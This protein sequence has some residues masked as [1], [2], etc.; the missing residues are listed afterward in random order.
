MQSRDSAYVARSTHL[1][2]GA[3]LPVDPGAS[4]EVHLSSFVRRAPA[5][6]AL[7]STLKNHELSARAREEFV[8]S[9][10][11]QLRA[12]WLVARVLHSARDIFKSHARPFCLAGRGAARR[13]R[14]RLCGFL[15]LPKV[16][17]V[18]RPIVYSERAEL[19]S[20]R[21]LVQPYAQTIPLSP[22]RMSCDCER[23]TVRSCY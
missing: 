6:H 23:W 22:A 20:F 13:R 14:L 7:P 9:A 21:S 8:P 4:D 19:R 5:S 1:A 16:G 3:Y 12:G 2:V 10:R 18:N 15:V 11:S 17:V